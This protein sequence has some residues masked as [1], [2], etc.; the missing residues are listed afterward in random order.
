MRVRRS[1]V[2]KATL[3]LQPGPPPPAPSPPADGGRGTPDLEVESY[4]NF[5]AYT[6]L[7]PSS[8]SV[9]VK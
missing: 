7:C 1:A 4:G 3:A 6:L 2:L 9:D 8:L 5:S